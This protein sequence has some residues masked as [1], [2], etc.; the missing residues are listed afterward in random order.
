[1]EKAPGASGCQPLPKRWVSALLNAGVSNSPPIPQHGQEGDVLTVPPLGPVFPGEPWRKEMRGIS[2][3]QCSFPEL[4]P[5]AACP[6]QPGAV[7]LSP[8]TPGKP[9]GPGIPGGPCS[10][11]G[12]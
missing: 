7:T 10:P 8:L 3:A 12:P 5:R 4:D 2:P 9:W 11:F 1:M 6:Q